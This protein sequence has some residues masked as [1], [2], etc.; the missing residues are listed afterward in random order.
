MHI[1]VGIDPVAAHQIEVVPAAHSTC[2][3]MSHRSYI[4]Y[5]TLTPVE[6]VAGIG[7]PLSL[8]ARIFLL[9]SNGKCMEYKRK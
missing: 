1:A 2:F 9:D 4:V 6:A 8:D 7:M 3:F 5:T